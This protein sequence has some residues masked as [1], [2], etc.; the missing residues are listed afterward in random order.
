MAGSYARGGLATLRCWK[1][2]HEGLVSTRARPT[3]LPVNN[4]KQA[5][6]YLRNSKTNGV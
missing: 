1:W 2:S 6:P 5:I 3:D 4:S